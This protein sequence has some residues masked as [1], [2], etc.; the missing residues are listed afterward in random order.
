MTLTH[1]T[2]IKIVLLFSSSKMATGVKRTR[3]LCL[4]VVF[5]PV[6]QHLHADEESLGVQINCEETRVRITV[7]T[8]FMEARGFPIG[9]E[10]IR[11]GPKSS[12]QRSCGPEEPLSGRDVIISAKLRDCGTESRVRRTNQNPFLCCC[13]VCCVY[14]CATVTFVLATLLLS[15]EMSPFWDE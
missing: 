2:I 15:T 1:L 14:I 12:R 5:L 9:P 6:C 13:L 3:F 4:L 11:L 10:H 8:H 7:S